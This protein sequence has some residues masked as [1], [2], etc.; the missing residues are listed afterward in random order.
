MIPTGDLYIV[1]KE[2]AN[3]LKQDEVLLSVGA[4]VKERRGP[5]TVIATLTSRSGD[6]IGVAQLLLRSPCITEADPDI[7]CEISTC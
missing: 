5:H 1:F 3:L 2:G 4:K 6:A 7:L